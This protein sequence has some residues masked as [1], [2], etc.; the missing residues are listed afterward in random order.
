MGS[1]P[2]HNVAF[3]LTPQQQIYSGNEDLVIP[4][5]IAVDLFFAF[6]RSGVAFTVVDMSHGL[7]RWIRVHTLHVLNLVLFFFLK[8]PCQNFKK[9]KEK[10]RKVSGLI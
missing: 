9:K 6:Y 3:V 8:K 1:Q 5:D 10:K 4:N 2:I 7:V